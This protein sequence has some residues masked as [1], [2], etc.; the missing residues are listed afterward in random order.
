[1]N[2]ESKTKMQ[3]IAELQEIRLQYDRLRRF[4]HALVES[5]S[6][7]KTLYTLL[8]LLSDN[9]PDLLWAKDMDNRYLFA[10]KAMCDKLLI[11]S[12]VQEPVGKTDLYFAERERAKHPERNDWHTFGEICA[13]SDIQIRTT[14]QPGRFEEYG[15][16]Q[17]QYL[18]LDVHKAPLIDGDGNM[19][20]VVGS[21]RDL[22]KEK[23]I[24]QELTKSEE[25]YKALISNLPNYVFVYN[26]GKIVYVN[27]LSIKTLGLSEEKIMQSSIL[28]FVDDSYKQLASENMQKRLSGKEIPDY[29]LKVV[30][31][32]GRKMDM[33]VRGAPIFFQHE[34]AYMI[35]LTDI[36]DRKIIEE[37]LKEYAGELKELNATKDKFFSIIAHDLKG[38]FNAILGF[39]ELLSE[40][41]DDFDEDEKKKFIHNIKIASD[42][43]FK[44]L[45]NLLDWSRLQT[46]KINPVP[47]MIDLSLLTV[48]NISVLKSM[49]DSKHI[50]L[51]SSIQYNTRVYA[52]A[53]MVRTVIRNLVSNAI[54]FTPPGGEV[55]IVAIENNQMVEFCVADNG[56]GI[57][58]DRKNVLFHIEEKI[59]TQ[60]T[61][62]ETGTGLG[63]LLC[64]EMIERQGGHIWVESEEGK[65]SRFY[66]NLPLSRL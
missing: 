35:V 28:D 26:K 33:I 46:G 30:T 20:G 1:M 12:D 60:G 22:T 37:Q 9:M 44:L 21:A 19:I 17:G 27:E 5:E 41:Y 57:S 48:E 65:G 64:K 66:F 53:N 59:S 42:S 7:Y 55:R 61:A 51:Y 50:K 16:V 18:F 10:N 40:S 47:E 2:D 54:K 43:T 62:N 58:N 52:D 11:A 29:E 45:E 3:L 15:N 14:C 63:L 32:D 34:P 36:T 25:G 4:E 6:R 13:D 38:P 56:V 24:E 49:A 23:L 8:R 31:P 39:S